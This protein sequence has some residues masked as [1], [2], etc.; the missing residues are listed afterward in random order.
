[1][2]AAAVQAGTVRGKPRD[3]GRR[4]RIYG[5]RVALLWIMLSVWQ[6]VSQIKGMAF[7]IS[8]PSAIWTREL[9]W[10][11]DGTLLFHTS[12]TLEETVAGFFLGAVA[13]IAAGF[14]IGPQRDLGEVL[15]PFII[16][17]YSIPKVALAPLFIVWFGIGIWMKIILAMVTV[18]FIVFFN[19]V[20][21]VRNVDPDLVNAVWLMGGSA[22][23]I[24]FKVI[25]PHALSAALTGVRIAIPYA[26]I[27]AIV[28]ELIASN[29]GIGY[30]VS[31]AA[32]QFDTAGVFAA[33]IV[34]TILATILN[35]LV[36]VV[37]RQTSRWKVD[38]DLTLRPN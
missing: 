7:Y 14:I 16:A 23:E 20:A 12:I 38:A 32:S 34:L 37:D 25:V 19:T 8:S 22:R 10:L 13:G 4:W 33:L 31:S 26:L 1:M 6:G 28:G 17:L 35:S 27:G 9:Q 36:N 29:R 30:L 21:G 2:T 11:A 24:L 15:D 3:A 18:F 5:W